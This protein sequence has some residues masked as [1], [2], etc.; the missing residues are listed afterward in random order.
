M[1]RVVLKTF[2]ILEM[3]AKRSDQG[4]TLTEISKELEFNQATAANIITT[5]VSRGY[6]EHIGKKK[7][8]KL[9]PAAFGLTNDVAYGQELVEAARDVME[10]LTGKLNE[11]CLLGILRHNKRYILHAVNST[12][13]IQVQVQSER[14]VYETASGRLL[15]AYLSEKEIDKFLQQNGLPV[16]SLW[17]EASTTGGL[18]KALANIRKEGISMTSVKDRHVRG[19][20]VPIFMQEKVVAGISVFLPDYRCTLSREKEIIKSLKESAAVISARLEK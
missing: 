6:L 3:V 14:N 20:A 9:G 13:E 8:Y 17:S 15:M 10:K 16:K 2:D 5:M 12:Q 4:A 19:F 1:V 11:C 7:G 18:M